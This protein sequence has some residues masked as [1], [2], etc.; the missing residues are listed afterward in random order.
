MPEAK[1]RKITA[2]SRSAKTGKPV[3]QSIPAAAA[4]RPKASQ[5]T[6]PEDHIGERIAQIRERKQLTHDG[7]SQLTKVVDLERKG[8]ARTT[9]RAYELG[10]YKPG[11]REIR[12]LAA[13]LEVSPSWLVLGIRELGEPD[14]SPDGS[15]RLANADEVSRTTIP[16]AKYV[17][18]LIAFREID[19]PD[20]DAACNLVLSLARLKIGEVEFRRMMAIFQDLGDFFE[21]A[22]RDT[23]DGQPVNSEELLSKIAQAIAEKYS[24]DIKDFVGNLVK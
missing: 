19:A 23:R 12:V 24:I 14:L 8:I 3:D 22:W 2:S 18:T 17:Q 11:A 10:I 4:A 20:R 9:I 13:A 5:P 6:L 15:Q 7:L 1:K 21:D 16:L